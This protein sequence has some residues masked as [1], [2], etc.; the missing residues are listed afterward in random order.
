MGAGAGKNRYRCA[1]IRIAY[2]PN[3]TVC[4]NIERGNRKYAKYMSVREEKL[5]RGKYPK[6]IWL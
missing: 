3:E 5:P 6:G 1:C 2:A 4:V